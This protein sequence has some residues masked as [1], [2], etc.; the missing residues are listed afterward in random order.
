M[1][2]HTRCSACEYQR[3]SVCK[4]PDQPVVA[5]LIGDPRADTAGSGEC[6]VGKGGA[7]FGDPEERCPQPPLRDK[8]V[9]RIRI[10]QFGKPSWKIG[11]WGQQRLLSQY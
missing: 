10:E 4:E 7:V 5:Y 2:G 3:R 11:C 9:D 6:L 1:G 8:F